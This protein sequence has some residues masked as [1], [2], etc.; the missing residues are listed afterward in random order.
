[1]RIWWFPVFFKSASDEMQT[2]V[3]LLASSMFNLQNKR[4]TLNSL[5]PT[6]CTLVV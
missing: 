2:L 1:V 6:A 4:R 5:F 3:R